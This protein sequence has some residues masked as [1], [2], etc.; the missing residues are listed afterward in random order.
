MGLNSEGAARIAFDVETA[1]LPDAGDYLEQPDAP[2][3]YKDPAKIAAFI[4]EKHAENLERCG[5]DVD[6]CRVVALGFQREG[7]D[8]L[9]SCA[10][11]PTEE[12]EMLQ[13]FWQQVGD[14]H[15]IG[16]N[17]LAFDL[18]VLLRRSLYLGL[19]TPHLV[20]DK[21]RHPN[22]TD[23]MRELDFN[24][25]IKSRGLAFY[26]KRFGLVSETA[27]EMT[28]ADVAQAVK[29]GWWSE[30]LAHCQADVEKTAALAARLGLFRMVE[31]GVL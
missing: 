10:H 25:A 23:L 13:A 11:D 28:G 30:I 21:Y 1:P 19:P 7:G 14:R 22:V 9:V 29:D 3:N 18:P 26:A 27:D 24:G 31:A 5:L 4:A 12:R 6:L 16:F 15:L 17:C 20:I 8:V 2:G